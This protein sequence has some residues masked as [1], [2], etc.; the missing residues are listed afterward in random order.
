MSRFENKSLP[1]Q[2]PETKNA[3]RK[4]IPVEVYSRV[5]G[6]YRPVD[7]WNKGKKEEF[8][9]RKEFTLESIARCIAV[10]ID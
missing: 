5:V 2:F 9:Q 8:E 3:S 1:E 6:Y 4:E 7:Q 10:E